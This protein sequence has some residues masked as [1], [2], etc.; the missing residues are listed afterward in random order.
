VASFNYNINLTG[1]CQNNG[2]G[3]IQVGFSG[4]TPP[5]TVA[6]A[7]PINQTA[8]LIYDFDPL[9]PTTTYETYSFV[10]G[11]SAATYSFRVND[12]TVPINLEYDVN[13]PVSS[14]NCTNILDVSATTC[15]TDSGSVTADASSDFSETEY[16][17]YASNN[18]LLQ[19]GVTGLGLFTFQ[20]LSA[21]TYFV[22]S[23]DYGGCSGTSSTFIVN[24]SVVVDF[25]FYP[26]D[27]T[28][29]GQASGKII[30]TGQTGVQPFTYQW[31]DGSTGST[32][33]G[34]TAG[35]YS[36]KVTDATGCFTI[37]EQTIGQIDPVGLGAFTI[38]AI[39]TCLNTDGVLTMT[40]TGGTGPYYY[41]A[42]TGAI[43]VSYSQSF[44][45]N[46]I[47]AGSYNFSVTDAALCKFTT[48]VDVATE[49]GI[50]DIILEVNPSF[51]SNADGSILVTA[52]GGTSPFTYTLVYPDSSTF[53]IT[54]NAASYTFSELSGGTYT[55]ILEDSSGCYFL[56]ESAILSQNSFTIT[57]STTGT[58]CA[59]NNGTIVVEKSVGG[60]SPF[61][62]SLDG[63]QNVIDTTASAVTFSNVSAGQHTISVTDASGC[64][65]TQQ[66]T[67]TPSTPLI[68][69]L[70]STSCGQGSEGTITAFISDGIPPFTYDWSDNVVSN[71]QQIKVTGLTAGTY[72]LTVL[73]SSGCSQTRTTIIDCDKTYVSYQSY[74]MGAEQFNLVSPTKRGILQMLNE[75]FDDLT[76]GNTNCDLVTT[77]FYAKVQVQPIGVVLEELFFTGTSLI[78]PPSDSLWYST[79]ESMLESIYGIG[80]VT[81]NQ[82]TNEITIETDRSETSLNGQEVIIELIIVYDIMC[83][84]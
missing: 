44:T 77:E 1:D 22:T 24:N 10:S 54:S 40:I 49:N 45:L 59:A 34:L 62:Y 76:T 66:V 15:N 21:G 57:A 61:D 67:I 39:P 71:P 4:G 14:G 84:T 60:T 26:V 80:N 32:L 23:V 9:N 6:W 65:Q 30:V 31:N 68:Y 41:S 36:V 51:C 63:I 16:Y 43:D 2:S 18:E 50:S 20:N 46:G 42:S 74:V 33:S 79:I 73:D 53:S 17:L 5:Y 75:G 52:L 13:V 25:G 56:S 64:T 37:K 81:V 19:S 27:D 7:P 58:T 38:D 28:Q 12:S 55:V 47:P 11:L 3:A 72:S 8:V 35:T 70:Y 48:G 78:Q 69:N 82:L 83:L 29:C